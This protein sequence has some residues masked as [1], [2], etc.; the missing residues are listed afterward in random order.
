[1]TLY[2]QIIDEA[3]NIANLQMLF[4]PT[5]TQIV[6][7]ISEVV[8]IKLQQKSIGAKLAIASYK[9]YDC[10]TLYHKVA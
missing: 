7:A 10:G 3:E 8:G 5:D 4:D 9:R 2:D 6:D 1:M